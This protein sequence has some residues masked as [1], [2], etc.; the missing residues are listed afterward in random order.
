MTDGARAVETGLGKALDA[1]IDGANY[2]GL[3]EVAV[4]IDLPDDTRAELAKLLDYAAS[5]TALDAEDW[6]DFADAPGD[7]GADASAAAVPQDPEATDRGALASLV[8]TYSVLL[9]VIDARRRQGNISALLM[10]CHIMSEYFPLLAWES[11][12]GHAA[13]PPQLAAYVAKPGSLWGVDA[14][15]KR[16]RDCAHPLSLRGSLRN[17]I[18][19][20]TRNQSWDS[21]EYAR[22]W[23]RY[24]DRDHSR[25][26]EGLAICGRQS[27]GR[28]DELRACEKKCPVG[29]EAPGDREALADKL[30]L[31]AVFTE[32]DLIA[33]RH[34]AP[35]GHGFGVPSESE[36]EHAW[37]RTWAELTKPWK[38]QRRNPLEGA[39]GAD[40]EALPGLGA[41]V[42]AVAGREVP[43]AGVLAEVD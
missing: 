36:L 12:L 16:S 31:A 24:L 39:V 32:S 22:L 7:L 37:K 10:I 34:S 4:T 2:S 43:P 33:L 1:L 23:R 21:E 19:V 8:P 35:V 40:G 25:V 42:S 20:A 14:D 13:D 27:A 6:G 18:H 29:S 3:R 15:D 5:I 9:D 30:A 26:A 17:A 28:P 11:H 41:L 38:G